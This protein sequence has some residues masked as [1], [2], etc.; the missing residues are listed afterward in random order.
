MPWNSSEWLPSLVLSSLY[1]DCLPDNLGPSFSNID[2]IPANLAAEVVYNLALADNNPE[3]Q[4]TG[5]DIFHLYNPHTTPWSE[6]VLAIIDV[7]YASSREKHVLSIVSHLTW[8]AR[9]EGSVTRERRQ[10]EVSDTMALAVSNPAVKLLDFYRN[11][12]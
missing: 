2:W 7:A 3:E 11:G 9:L 1:L 6:L 4:A 12:L 5:A 10:D 8:L